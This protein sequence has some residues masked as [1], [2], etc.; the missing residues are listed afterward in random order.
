ML[1]N[2]DEET[3]HEECK[4]CMWFDEESNGFCKYHAK[5]VEENEVACYKWEKERNWR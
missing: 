5:F 4:T 3:N 1:Y 2:F